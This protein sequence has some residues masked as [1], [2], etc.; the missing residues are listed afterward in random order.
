MILPVI[1]P[2]CAGTGL[3]VTAKF[4]AGPLPQ[5]LFAVTEIFPQ[6]TQERKSIIPE[7]ERK[8]K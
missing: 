3:T 6:F 8:N 5:L 4:C 1:V 7:N 2:G